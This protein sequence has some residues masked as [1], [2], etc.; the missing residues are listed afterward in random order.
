M[1]NPSQHSADFT[2]QL[3][4]QSNTILDPNTQFWYF[5]PPVSQ[6]A[7]ASDHPPGVDPY[8]NSVS[9]ALTHVGFQSQPPLAEDPN[10]ASQSWLVK[11]AEPISYEP[12]I[13]PLNE[14]LL[15][16]T[17][18]NSLWN[19]NW[20]NQPLTYNS[21]AENIPQQT[22]AAFPGT[23]NG[24]DN[25]SL[26]SEPS[27]VGGQ[28]INGST[29]VVASEE[30]ETKRR[31]VLDSGAAVGFVKICAMC[32]VTTNSPE[33]FKKHLAGKRHAAKANLMHRKAGPYSAAAIQSKSI[34]IW[35]KDPNKVK[36]VQSVWCDFCKINCN[37]QDA[38]IKHIVGRKHQRN[39][40]Q[41][42]KLK[43]PTTNV[44]SA[45]RNA[46]I[47]PMEKVSQS[48]APS[49]EDLETKKQKVINGGAA[50]REVRTC[51]VCNVVCNSQ[52]AFSSHLSGQKHAAMM[53]KQAVEARGSGV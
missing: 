19:S 48:K 17:T 3:P 41:L 35:K 4:H 32:N 30:L 38:Y 9:Y 53:M 52:I 50:A 39:L 28:V 1:F 31:R 12:S 47:G 51:T 40:D 18:A 23:S 15:V 43:N 8:A 13:N 49:Q 20:T 11:Q 29:G 26:P 45:A 5:P 46:Q 21:T 14:S 22:N 16:P 24:I 34:G 7:V 36:L 25:A 42:E 33:V 2:Y 44:P 37:S 6:S 27:S 10:A